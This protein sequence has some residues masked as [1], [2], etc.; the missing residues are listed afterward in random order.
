MIKIQGNQYPSDFE[1]KKLIVD[2]GKQM[3]QRGY[4]IAADGSL[5]VRVGPNA[6]WIT[7]EDSQ[8]SGITQDMMVRVDLEGKLLLGT[9]VKALPDEI[10]IHL[11]L[12]REQPKL[13]AVLHGY[14]PV[15]TAMGVCGMGLTSVGYTKALRRLGDVP[16]IPYRCGD[17]DM[18]EVM[19]C[20]GKGH[21]VLFQN[22][23][24]MT[25]G[26]SLPEAYSLMETMEYAGTLVTEVTRCRQEEIPAK[27]AVSPEP[28]LCGVT[29]LISP[30][31]EVV[32]SAQTSDVIHNMKEE[33]KERDFGKVTEKPREDVMAEVV[34]RSMSNF[35]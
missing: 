19:I 20:A 12:Y 24:C 32:C 13:R 33:K 34:R 15:T 2:I 4:V 10:K 3:A 29:E 26:E 23:G 1:A 5:S 8:K 16:V 11:N 30:P 14:P 35:H 18:Q 27:K 31:K 21:G 6:V 9:K 22:N 25:W 17:I 28:K 7:T